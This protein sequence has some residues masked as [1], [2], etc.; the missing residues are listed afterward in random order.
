[1]ENQ[2]HGIVLEVFGGEDAGV[3]KIY[4]GVGNRL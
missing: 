4:F 2:V 1:V 3:I